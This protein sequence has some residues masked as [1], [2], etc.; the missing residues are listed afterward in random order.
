VSLDTYIVTWERVDDFDSTFTG[1]V[2]AV[3]IYEAWDAVGAEAR[4]AWGRTVG[5]VVARNG[6]GGS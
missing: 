6:V 4:L 3:D 2:L 5:P 1:R